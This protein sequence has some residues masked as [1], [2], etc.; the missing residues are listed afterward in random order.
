[1]NSTDLTNKVRNL[2]MSR[3]A[4]KVGIAPSSALSRALENH[5]PEDFLPSAESVISIAVRIGKSPILNLPKSRGEYRTIYDAAN[6]KLNNLSVEVA[7]FLEE[8]DYEALPIPASTP[9]DEEKLT[10]DIS[11]KHA[12]VAA[13]LG[14][15]G[16]NN[17][18]LTPEYGPYVRFATVLT[19]APLKPDRP[20]NADLCLGEKCMRCIRACP[21]GALQKPKH[22]PAEGWRINKKKCHTYVHTVLDGEI[23][24]LCIKA[25][26]AGSRTRRKAKRRA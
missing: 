2:A 15:F 9:Y 20:L 11:H 17:L 3:G 23:C 4:A 6:A 25:C 8:Q 10:G 18:V 16:V 13:G 14:R 12:A 26:P 1:M 22:N 24:G 7:S 19:N 21:A 5:H